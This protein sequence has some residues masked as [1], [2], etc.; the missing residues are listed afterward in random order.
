M[1]DRQQYD[2]I[3]S[4][5]RLPIINLIKDLAQ[6]RGSANPKHF[7]RLLALLAFWH[8]QDYFTKSYITSLKTLVES[9]GQQLPAEVKDIVLGKQKRANGDADAPRKRQKLDPTKGIQ[10]LGGIDNVGEDGDWKLPEWHGGETAPWH[11]LPAAS[12]LRPLRITDHDRGSGM[13]KNEVRAI[14]FKG[15]NVSRQVRK[16]VLKLIKQADEIYNPSPDTG[17]RIEYDQMGRKLEVVKVR[18]GAD[19]KL[20][21]VV[22]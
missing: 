5:L 3:V 16:E 22:R 17:K 20:K 10:V 15:D 14:K 11:L 1:R 12:W 2:E 8:K 6:F 13:K 21:K 4:T 9:E 18:K 19:G 7:K